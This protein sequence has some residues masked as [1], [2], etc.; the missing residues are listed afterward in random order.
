MWRLNELGDIVGVVAQSV[1]SRLAQLGDTV[2]QLVDVAS[3]SV[4][5]Y[6]G[7]VS[8]VAAGSVRGYCGSVSG[9]A[10]WLS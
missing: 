5:G 8:D 9:C 2:I 6:C 7:S 10:I 3:G 1:M 4:R